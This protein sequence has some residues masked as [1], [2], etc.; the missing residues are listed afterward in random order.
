MRPHS[1]SHRMKVR[2]FSMFQ[3]V[4][5]KELM[6]KAWEKLLYSPS[7][8]H[9]KSRNFLSKIHS[10]TIFS[11]SPELCWKCF[12]L[13]SCAWTEIPTLLFWPINEGAFTC[14]LQGISDKF[15]MFNLVYFFIQLTPFCI[16]SLIIL[17]VIG[18]YILLHGKKG[19]CTE[20]QVPVLDRLTIG[21]KHKLEDQRFKKRLNQCTANGW[22]W[23]YCSF[24]PRQYRND[25][26]NSDAICC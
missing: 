26:F 12:S 17:W 18:R 11:L 19:T 15:F 3:G 2:K 9:M 4:D 23:L 10:M 1:F 20:G 16:E 13:H 6:A 22:G 14:R 25:G 24:L 21:E 7:P 5:S 8:R